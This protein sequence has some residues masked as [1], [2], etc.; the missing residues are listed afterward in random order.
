MLFF[1]LGGWRVLVFD[2]LSYSLVPEFSDLFD[3]VFNDRTIIM[4]MQI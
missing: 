3:C 2:Y 4:P 1:K